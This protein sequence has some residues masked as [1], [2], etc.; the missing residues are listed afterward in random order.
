[1]S[2]ELNPHARAFLRSVQDADDPTRADQE[3]VHAKVKARLAA[4]IAAGIAAITTSKAAAATAQVAT[5]AAATGIVGTA[6][7][8]AAVVAGGAG[9]AAVVGKIAAACLVVAAV[10][11]GATAVVHQS[12]HAA[13][14]KPASAPTVVVAATPP[15][16]M[17]TS[18]SPGAPQA[19]TVAPES[20]SDVPPPP[21][22]A[23]TPAEPKAARLDAPRAA[24]P[25]IATP[26]ATVAEVVATSPLDEEIALVRDARAA[27]RAGEAAQSLAVLDEHDRRF[28]GGALTED[29]AAERIYALCALGRTGEARALAT[30]FLADHPVSPHAASVRASCGASAG[31][32]N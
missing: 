25:P 8:P 27:L 30:R 7:A 14:A 11:G 31:G 15:G 6:A 9:T 19:P 17:R 28:P 12:R 18:T 26:S 29:V 1:M 32:M 4:G 2:D 24:P 22:V 5:T 3:R 10:A 20:T 13:V 21:T 16:P 23:A